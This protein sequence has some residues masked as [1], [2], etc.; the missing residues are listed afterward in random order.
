MCWDSQYRTCM[1]PD[2]P[3]D[4]GLRWSAVPHLHDQHG[5]ALDNLVPCSLDDGMGKNY[6]PYLRQVI[7]SVLTSK[8]LDFPLFHVLLCASGKEIAPRKSIPNWPHG[9][10][11]WRFKI[12]FMTYSHLVM[13]APSFLNLSTRWFSIYIPLVN[14]K[15]CAMT[16]LHK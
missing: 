9:R 4:A 11:K 5:V 3:C 6:G 2:W 12:H 16:R 13:A 10:F 1:W 8:W 14:R 7:H 15:Y